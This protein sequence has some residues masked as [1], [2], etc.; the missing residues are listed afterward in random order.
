[1]PDAQNVRVEACSSRPFECSISVRGVR[2]HG[3][4]TRSVVT[5]NMHRALLFRKAAAL[6]RNSL[7]QIKLFGA[8]RGRL[9]R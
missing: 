7:V 2:H 5:T 1:M 3:R 4:M 9:L 6:G 8:D